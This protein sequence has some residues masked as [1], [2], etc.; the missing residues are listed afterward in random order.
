MTDILVGEISHARDGT[1]LDGPE[2]VTALVELDGS[3]LVAALLVALLRGSTVVGQ[4]LNEEGA[5]ENIDVVVDV[6]L[7]FRIFRS[8]IEH[9]ENIVLLYIPDAALGDSLD[10]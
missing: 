4:F 6:L 2:I 10:G 5:L 7:H 8:C 1:L 3:D 9:T